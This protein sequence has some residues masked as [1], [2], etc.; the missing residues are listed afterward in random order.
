MKPDM[1][2]CPA[3][4]CLDIA[5]AALQGFRAA[6]G[7]VRIVLLCQVHSRHIQ[8]DD[9]PVLVNL[10]LVT[11]AHATDDVHNGFCTSVMVQSCVVLLRAVLV[12]ALPTLC[13]LH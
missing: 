11:A 5:T 12:V 3:D 7:S 6:P 1:C 2:L 13:K 4:E 8:A 9:S 10:V